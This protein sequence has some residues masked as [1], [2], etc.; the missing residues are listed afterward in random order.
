MVSSDSFVQMS[1][2][3][4]EGDRAAAVCVLSGLYEQCERRDVG[5]GRCTDVR[6]PSSHGSVMYGKECVQLMCS[7]SA[8]NI[9]PGYICT[10]KVCLFT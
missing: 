9:P 6:W 1:G 10:D 4:C 7:R 2:K 8:Y 3:N 5:W